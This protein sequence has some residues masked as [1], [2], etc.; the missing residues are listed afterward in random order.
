MSI[1]LQMNNFGKASTNYKFM[2][3]Q[4]KWSISMHADFLT[5]LKFSDKLHTGTI[6]AIFSL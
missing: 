4:F 1:F 2:S 5:V 3:M 6:F